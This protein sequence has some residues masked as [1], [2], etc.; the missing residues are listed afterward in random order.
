MSTH[1]IEYSRLIAAGPAMVA[2]LKIILNHAAQGQHQP[3]LAKDQ[4]FC[5]EEL[6]RAAL[7]KATGEKKWR[8]HEHG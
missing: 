5:I 1:S 2:A 3:E 4:C 8:Q 6:A 7:A